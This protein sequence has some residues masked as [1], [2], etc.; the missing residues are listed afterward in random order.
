MY[1]ACPEMV[2]G[3]VLSCCRMWLEFDGFHTKTDDI[4]LCCCILYFYRMKAILTVHDDFIK[5]KHFSRYWPIAQGIQRSPVNSPHKGQWRGALMLSLICASTNDWANNRDAGDLRRHRAH[6]DATVMLWTILVN[7][8]HWNVGLTDTT[9]QKSV[10]RTPL[11]ASYYQLTRYGLMTPY[12]DIN[13][14]QHWLR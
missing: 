3:P 11:L 12:S 8:K 6:Y 7:I 4:K 14:R 5:W 2:S 10:R 1:P 13:V 9:S